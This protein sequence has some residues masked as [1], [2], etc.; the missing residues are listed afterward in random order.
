MERK[1]LSSPLSG[2]LIYAIR[3][4]GDA[5]G[6]V[7]ETSAGSVSYNYTWW[8]ARGIGFVKYEIRKEGDR[9]NSVTTILLNK[10]DIK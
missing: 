7:T 6:K 9:K 8:L 3:H 10:V 4:R 1:P 5:Y 2:F